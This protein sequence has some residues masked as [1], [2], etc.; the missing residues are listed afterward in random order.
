MIIANESKSCEYDRLE[1]MEQ[2]LSN[3]I[4]TLA[5]QKDCLDRHTAAMETLAQAIML[6]EATIERKLESKPRKSSPMV[7]DL[8][9]MFV[10][11]EI[12]PRYYYEERHHSRQDTANAS[13]DSFLALPGSK[14]PHR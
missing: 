11:Y 5:E 6:H 9:K 2:L 3:L 8:I 13:K 12:N 1:K 4:A 14:R 7:D 10:E